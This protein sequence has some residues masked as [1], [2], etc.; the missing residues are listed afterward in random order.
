MVRA[1]LRYVAGPRRHDQAIR[2]GGAAE[3]ALP[4]RELP[5]GEDLRERRVHRHA[6]SVFVRPLSQPEL[7][8]TPPIYR[9]GES[10]RRRGQPIGYPPCC[11]RSKSRLEI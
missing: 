3:D 10:G 6:A 7:G 8:A 11:K 1:A 2:A 5:R 9:G 4:V